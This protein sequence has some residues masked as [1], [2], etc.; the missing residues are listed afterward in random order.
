MLDFTFWRDA[1]AEA[2][3]PQLAQLAA[4]PFLLGAISRIRS[5]RG[6]QDHLTSQGVRLMACSEID[7]RRDRC[8]RASKFWAWLALWFSWPLVAATTTKNSLWLIPSPSAKSQSTLV[9]SN[10]SSGRAFGPALTP[11]IAGGSIC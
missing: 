9:N 1:R 6:P 4:I 3:W 2:L 8:R 10:N 5:P 11:L 7:Y